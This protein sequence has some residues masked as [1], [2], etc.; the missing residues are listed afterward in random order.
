MQFFYGYY[1]DLMITRCKGNCNHY[2]LCNI[3]VIVSQQ[4]THFI[5]Q[6]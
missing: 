4:M 2:Y 5:N 1:F 3:P 6:V